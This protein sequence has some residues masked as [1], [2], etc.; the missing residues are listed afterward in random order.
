MQSISQQLSQYPNADLTRSTWWCG[1]GCVWQDC[2]AVVP[3]NAESDM[4]SQPDY[5]YQRAPRVLYSVL[6]IVVK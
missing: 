5:E 2:C 3:L 6:R 4:T 1:G